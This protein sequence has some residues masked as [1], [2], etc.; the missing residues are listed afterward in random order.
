MLQALHARGNAVTSATGSIP[1]SSIQKTNPVDQ[2]D[3]LRTS[4]LEALKDAVQARDLSVQ[5]RYAE[6]ILFGKRAVDIYLKFN[7]ALMRLAIW[8]NATGQPES[9][10]KYAERNLPAARRDE[11][12][13]RSWTRQFGITSLL[14]GIR[15]SG[16]RRFG[17]KRK[18]TQAFRR[19]SRITI[20]HSATI[21][22][23]NSNK[24][25][26]KCVR[27]CGSIPGLPGS[28]AIPHPQFRARAPQSF[29]G[30]Q[31]DDRKSAA[32]EASRD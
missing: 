28:S 16:S 9:A 10:A 11:S 14:Q 7:I 12:V 8:Y 13:L 27:C 26:R 21:R 24:R 30:G 22:S 18:R 5:G 17:Y 20:L 2:L 25:L 31:R 4:R 15:T 19:C 23:A 1:L 3:Q 32:T 29:R 6:A